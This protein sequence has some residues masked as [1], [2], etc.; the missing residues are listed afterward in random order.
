MERRNLTKNLIIEL[1]IFIK[2]LDFLESCTNNTLLN[3]KF[4]ASSAKLS[5]SGNEDKVLE[6]YLGIANGLLY[7]HF[8][9]D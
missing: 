6:D 3:Y 5:D 7:H 8:C 2:S 9:L 4:L 1:E